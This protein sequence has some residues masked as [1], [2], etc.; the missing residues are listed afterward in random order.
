MTSSKSDYES[1]RELIPLY[2][3]GLLSDSQKAEVE[4]AADEHAELRTEIDQW[5]KIQG[6]YETIEG[7]IPQPS[8][9]LYSRIAAGIKEQDQPGFFEKFMLSKKLALSFIAAQFLIIV[10]LGIYIL[11]SKPEYSTL[12]APP[13]ETDSLI[14]IHIIFKETATEAD[15]RKLLLQVHARIISGPSMSGLYVIELPSQEEIDKSL[16]ILQGNKIV[17]FAEKAY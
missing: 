3:K 14:K 6:A 10:A 1:V 11:Q 13:S 17:E 12:S 9:T 15:I 5:K 4:R 2:V 7:K 8:G 16:S